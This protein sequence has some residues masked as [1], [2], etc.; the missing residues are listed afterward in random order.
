MT[1]ENDWLGVIGAIERTAGR[2]DGLVN[3]AGIAVLA[4]IEDTDYATWKRVMAINLDGTFLGCKHA[5][6]LMRES[7][8][9]SIVNI[10]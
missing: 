4:T 7:Q 8:P 9:G 5:L 3:A 2:L 1:S 10:S 6:P